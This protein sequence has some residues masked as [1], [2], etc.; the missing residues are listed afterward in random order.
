MRETIIKLLEKRPFLFG[1]AQKLY[2]ASWPLSKIRFWLMKLKKRPYF[3]LLYNSVQICSERYQP[4]H[5]LIK[6][7]IASKCNIHTKFK[8]LEIGSWAGQSAILWAS[9]C[10]ENN[11]GI[12]FVIDTWMASENAPKAMKRATK[13]NKIFNLFLHNV[14][15]SGMQDYIVPIRGTSDAV[16][17]ILKPET[18]DFVYIDG[19]HSYTQFSQDL[20]NYMKVVKV[21]GIICGDDL[22]LFPHEVDIQHAKQHCDEDFILDKKSQKYFHP[23]VALGIHEVFENVSMKNGFWAMR[24]LQDGWETV[25]I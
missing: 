15:A 20:N 5:K 13:D 21:N 9:V 25:E 23:G 11:T 8:I 19:D 1:I 22:E 7:E 2:R 24:K 6:H 14:A 10:K 16:A 4:M 12:V 17:E 3:G 18:F